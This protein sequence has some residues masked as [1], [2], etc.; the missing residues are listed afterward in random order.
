MIAGLL[1]ALFAARVLH[2]NKTTSS[3][4][5]DAYHIPAGYS[6]LVTG[7]LRMRHSKPVLSLYL[8]GLPLLFSGVQ[9]SLAHPDWLKSDPK[10]YANEYESFGPMYRFGTDFLYHNAIPVE[11][12]VFLSR[13]A[14][15]L[16]ALLLSLLVWRLAHKLGG[17]EA[18]LYALVFFAFC[19]GMLAYAG[20]AN[21]DMIAT[22]FYFAAAF[23]SM[24]FLER[25]TAKRAALFGAALSCALLAKFS[26]VILLPALGLLWLKDGAWAPSWWRQ[27]A[28]PW[29]ARPS[30]PRSSCC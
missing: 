5:D 10:L 20:I 9:L 13:L 3:T 23:A 15:W 27:R 7:D 11:R 24:R 22:A 14:P 8:L 26:S 2:Q 29:R 4:Y 28:S 19:P 16:F 12:I 25:P 30:W 1:I 21:Q 18:G 17:G 6:M